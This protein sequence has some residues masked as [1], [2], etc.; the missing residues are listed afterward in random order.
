MNERYERNGISFTS[1]EL[2]LIRQKSFCVIGCGGLGGFVINAL[3]RFGIGQLTV[4]DGDV[5]CASNLNRQLFA[6]E[7][8]LG[9]NKALVCKKELVHINSEI[10]VTAHDKMLT[11][12]NAADILRGHDLIMDCLDNPDTRLLL[13]RCASELGITVIH[14]A[15]GGFW[16][17]ISTVYPGDNTFEFLYSNWSS[18]KTET[19]QESGNPVFTVQAISAIQCSEALK[20]LAGRNKE[21]KK[22][23]IY[24]DLLCNSI[25]VIDLG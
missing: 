9:Q 14:G 4:V 1:E 10:N 12:S 24:I 23:L 3:A 16:G 5:F 7:Q 25:E 21:K 15:I 19:Q 6:T 20:Y 17:H 13:G 11:E 8:N 2:T 22:S 18:V